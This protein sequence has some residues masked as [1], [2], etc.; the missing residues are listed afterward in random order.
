MISAAGLTAAAA[1]HPAR[2][3]EDAGATAA[4][5]PTAFE[6]ITVTARRSDERAQ[7][8]PIAINAF[9][10]AALD[11]R[12]IEQLRDLAKAVPSLSI[13]AT[14]SDV[15]TLY[16]GQVRIRGLAGGQVY[17][18]D[19]L[20]G[21][22]DRA[23]TT[24]LSHGLSPGYYFDLDSL[25]VY[26]GAQGTLFGRSAISG[27]IVIEPKRPTGKFEGYVET[28]F[29]DYGD[30]KNT[31]AINI[32][33]I[34]DKL[35]VRVAGQ[36]E[37]RDGYTL[38]L[39]NG[40][41][42]DN[43]NYY[44]WRVG[45][46]L[47]P[48]DDFE[49]YL[50]YDGYWQDS[51]GASTVMLGVNPDLV[52]GHFNKNLKLL[53]P[54]VTA[55]CLISLT[56]GG[57]ALAPVGN[58]P[59]GCGTYRVG[60]EPGIAEAFAR[61][62]ALGPRTIAA[63]ATSGIGKDYFYGF[64]DIAR[65]DIGERITLKNIVAARVTKQ[66]SAY[67]FTSTGQDVLTYGILGNNRGW[68]DNSI[69]YTE[70]I[71]LEGRSFNERLS[72][73]AG[74]YLLFSHPLGYTTEVY[75]A[76]EIPTYS[77]YRDVNR[78]Q[79]IFVHGIYDLSDYVENLRFSA[80][81][82]YSWDDVSQ[83]STATKPYETVTRDADGQPNDCFLNGSDRNCFH[84][85]ETK[86]SAPSWNLSVDEQIT[87][88][89]L[90]YL[91]A[92]STYHQGGLN[93]VLQAPLDRYGPERITDVELGVKSDWNLGDIRGRGNADVFHADY[94]SV[95]VSQFV[96]VPSATA[97]RAPSIQPVLANA[98]SAEL[99]GMEME[100][101]VTL[102]QGIDL[103]AQGSYF[104]ARYNRHPA[105]L[106]GGNPGFQYVPRFAFSAAATYHLPIDESWGKVSASIGWT[107]K[108]H[109]SITPLAAESIN[110][111][112]HYQDIDLHADWTGMFGRPVD[113]SF[114]M[115]N[116]TDNLHV[117]GSIPLLTVL[118]ATSGAYNA[119]RMFGFSLKYRFG[120]NG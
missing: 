82:R 69:Q 55:G 116:A 88:R 117:T 94:G 34:A 24:G 115:T 35:L 112:A 47:K 46:T 77:H 67:D 6:E 27:Q 74:G 29:G 30:R 32:P 65:W 15:N 102:P 75:A 16:S 92:G 36:M 107:W 37:Q 119:P 60:L 68:N 76:V 26:K 99:E 9:S 114:F 64:T 53:P 63:R 71:H 72:W 22:T 89:T 45:L 91:R 23:A 28:Q 12:H 4:P 80:G 87:P 42:L 79:A 44:S 100:Q 85:G 96:L 98:A 2:A 109:Q 62:Q 7:T 40:E 81:Y 11:R 56:L 51:N 58:I 1:V 43:R 61:Q 90:L 70:E 108:G 21:G 14:T 93:I 20:L 52:L 17:F 49:N 13:Y 18:A 25:D 97:G 83:G 106:G 101:T 59:S 78:S 31:V 41:H 84:G 57:P 50:L 118:G 103:E 95:Q 104:N 120:P 38:D 105:T 111:I 110:T 5:A 86:T 73:L 19:A 10:Q 33:V 39:Q 66:L 54:K 8:V 3:Q 48:S 113:S